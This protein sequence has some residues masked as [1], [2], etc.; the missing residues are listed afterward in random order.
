M[1]RKEWF[2]TAMIRDDLG[3]E[4]IECY[5]PNGGGGQPPPPSLCTLECWSSE[6][7]ICLGEEVNYSLLQCGFLCV[8]A[9]LV[10][11][12]G[13]PLCLEACLFVCG[14][15]AIANA[16]VCAIQAIFECGCF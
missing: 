15:E 16:V 4:P 14:F 6:L 7:L 1:V 12:P 3:R 2:A 9:S 5:T 11:G 8:A 13:Y 10:C